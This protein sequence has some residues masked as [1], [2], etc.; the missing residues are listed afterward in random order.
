MTPAGPGGGGGGPP[1]P[2]HGWNELPELPG[3]LAL[4]KLLQQFHQPLLTILL[5]AGLVKALLGYIQESR[6]E[7]AMASN[8]DPHRSQ[9]HWRIRITQARFDANAAFPWPSLRSLRLPLRSRHPSGMGS[10]SCRRCCVPRMS[11][12]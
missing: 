7:G 5:V 10:W 4:L 2:Q 9:A 6:A 8:T 1:P 11:W 12:S 3:Q